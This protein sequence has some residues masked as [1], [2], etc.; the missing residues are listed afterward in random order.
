M[1]HRF[2][3]DVVSIVCLSTVSL[4]ICNRIRIPTIVGFLLAGLLVG[5][6]GLSMVH[7]VEAVE[8]MAEIGVVLLL[9]TIGIEFSLPNLLKIRKTLIVGG[10]TQVGGTFCVTAAL[11][12]YSGMPA[13]RAVFLGLLIALSSTA[14]VLKTLQ[15]RGE[16]DLPHGKTTLAILIFQDLLV[17]PFMLFVPLLAGTVSLS[18]S[19]MAPFLIKAVACLAAVIVCARWILPEILHQV[20]KTRDSELFLFTVIAIGFGIAFVTYSIGLSL[21]LG[22]F[23]A[24]LI[25]S[26][27]QY[28]LRALGRIHPLRDIFISF[29]FVSIGMLLDLNVIAENPALILAGTALIIGGKFFF[30][31]CAGILIA[32]P[33]RASLLTGLSLAQV[34]EFSFILADSGRAAGLIDTNLFQLF[35]GM[36]IL[37]MIVTP[38]L[39]QW[40]SGIADALVK[41][42]FPSMLKHRGL[43]NSPKAPLCEHLIIIGYGLGGRHVAEASQACGIPHVIIEAN[44]ET[45]RAQKSSGKLIYH[46]DATSS[47]LLDHAGVTE[48]HAAVV[49]IGDPVATRRIVEEIRTINPNIYIIVRS[50]YFADLAPLYRLGA[51]EVIAEEYETSIEIFTRV[52]RRYFVPH[53]DIESLVERIRSNGYH[54]IRSDSADYKKI[55]DFVALLS[56]IDIRIMRVEKESGAAGKSLAELNLR[57]EY[58]ITIFAIIKDGEKVS[59]PDA[60]QKLEPGDSVI[61]VGL[62]E[63]LV[64]AETIFKA[65]QS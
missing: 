25:L 63:L 54:M 22:A 15:K 47:T 28:G 10:L 8:T 48:A 64:F 45:T 57:K 42:P 30:A 41:L 9:F 35:L 50:R 39:I 11:M 37:S 5:P 2:I 65:G 59:L 16:I 44:P 40:A 31:A 62:P 49:T 51:N 38:F 29:F 1:E 19:A 32:L 21:A 55:H 3:T 46:G 18:L 26:S 17:V 20:A 27:S 24:G 61:A 36:S 52:L 12:L 33:L 4:F 34:G 14:I 43:T 58:G 13:D 60:D 53:S 56:D 6:Y 23:L 7:S